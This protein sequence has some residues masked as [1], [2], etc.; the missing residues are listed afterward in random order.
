MTGRFHHH[1]ITGFEQGADDQVQPMGGAGSG[2]HLGLLGDDR[3]LFEALENLQAQ[4]RQA[5]HRAVAEQ[6]LHIGA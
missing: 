6:P 5:I 3:N 2:E 1:T 4:G